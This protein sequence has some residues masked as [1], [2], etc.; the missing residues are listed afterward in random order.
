VDELIIPRANVR[1]EKGARR[2]E[3]ERTPAARSM[4]LTIS[5]TWS[6]AA[7]V[8]PGQKTREKSIHQRNGKYTLRTWG[9]NIKHNIPKS[10]EKGPSGKKRHLS[11]LL[12]RVTPRKF[13]SKR[14]WK[15]LY[16]SQERRWPR[17]ESQENGWTRI[18]CHVKGRDNL[19]PNRQSIPPSR[20][21][22]GATRIAIQTKIQTQITGR[23]EIRCGY[24][25]QLSRGVWDEQRVTG[26]RKRELQGE[27]FDAVVE[28]SYRLVINPT[29]NSSQRPSQTTS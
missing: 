25:V 21:K 16:E 20:K 8:R 9:L 26:E 3:K 4:E 2:G 5:N 19:F 22:H 10:K 7:P 18:Q 12:S 23:Q 11:S 29:K 24:C 6:Q 17:R 13:A 15:Q 1:I 14:S 28:L 27:Y